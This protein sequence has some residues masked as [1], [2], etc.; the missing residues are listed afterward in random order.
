VF[1][2]GDKEAGYLA[3]V[4]GAIVAAATQAWGK[5][6]PAEL[7]LGTC[8]TQVG[9]NR[10]RVLTT[11]QTSL[12]ADAH[13]SFDPTMT[14]LRFTSAAGPLV[15]LV[16]LGCHPTAWGAPRL[17]SRDWPGVMIDRMEVQTGTPAMFC[18][19]C[20]GDV[21]PR[22]SKWLPQHQAFSAGTGNDWESVLEI[23]LRAAADALQTW[24]AIKE[25]RAELPLA[26]ASADQEL[27]YRPLPSREEAERQLA[28]AA[29]KRES[30]G[31]GMCDYRH[32]ASVLDALGG[33]PRRGYPYRQ[34]ITRLGPLAFVPVP[35]EVFSGI[36]L[37]LRAASPLPHT[38]LLSQA[39]GSIGYL[40][41]REAQHRGGYEV[42]VARAFGPYLPGET[43][44]DYLVE[45]NLAL[46]RQLTG[47]ASPQG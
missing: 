45:H 9:V 11:H 19:G 37:R 2:W 39:N 22:T 33:E 43:I 16:H 27:P 42:W 15:N 18:N 35:G 12:C 23:G 38:L 26:V 36:G 41:T 32:W 28:L 6:A 46:L 29:P 1:G 44:D 10:R 5:L 4:F 47:A 14:V 34:S 25:F 30:W 7:G 40:P 3:E 21:G 31:A 13:G 8:Q 24:A 17:A 20:I